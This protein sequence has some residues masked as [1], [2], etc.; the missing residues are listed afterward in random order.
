[1]DRANIIA[2]VLG[3]D[4]C[5][6]DEYQSGRYTIPV[7]QDGTNYYCCVKSWESTPESETFKWELVS[8]HGTYFVYKASCEEKP[9]D[10]SAMIAFDRI[11]VG[12]FVEIE[13]KRLEKRSEEKL[14]EWERGQ[15]KQSF[16]VGSDLTAKQ[17]KVV[18]LPVGYSFKDFSE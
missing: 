17:F 14:F 10:G 1:M 18:R 2:T 4:I 13:G 3:S 16:T 12:S 5:D 9:E 6:L 15:V 11:P 7:F 8:A